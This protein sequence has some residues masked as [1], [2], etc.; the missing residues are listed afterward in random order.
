MTRLSSFVIPM[1]KKSQL[2]KFS[3]CVFALMLMMPLFMVSCADNDLEPVYADLAIS[4]KTLDLKSET[5]GTFSI[6][7]G[8]GEYAI[9]SN[10][11]SLATA[12]LQGNVVTVTAQKEEGEVTISVTDKKTSQR[13]KVTVKITVTIA[14]LEVENKITTLNVYEK[15][16]I[17][18][19]AGSGF[20]SVNT[21]KF[22]KGKI[23]KDVLTI[24]GLKA[25]RG[26][27]VITDLKTKQKQEFEVKVM[28]KLVVKNKIKEITAG[29]TFK[30][31]I[32]SGSGS[33]TI[34]T[35]EFLS[36]SEANGTIIVLAVKPGAGKITIT[37]NET[38]QVQE[39]NIN[40][41]VKIPDLTIED[42]EGILIK[43][44]ATETYKILSGSGEYEIESNE[45]VETTLGNDNVIT[46]KGVQEGLAVINIRDKKTDQFKQI[47]VSII[48]KVQ[49]AIVMITKKSKGDYISVKVDADAKYRNAIWID[50][51]DNQ[52]K[53]KGE[54]FAEYAKF[55]RFQV[56]AKK[57]SIYGKVEYLTVPYGNLTS[58]DISG[59]QTLSTFY[60]YGSGLNNLDVTKNPNLKVLG[61]MSN[62]LTAI[63]LSSNPNL[64]EVIVSGNKMTSLDLTNCPKLKKLTAS[65]NELASV[66]FANNKKVESILIGHNKLTSLDVSNLDYL[67]QINCA[68]NQL[69]SINVDGCISLLDLY[70]VDN[71]LTTLNITD[72][73]NLQELS[74]YQNQ[75]TA[76]DISKN[77]KLTYVAI[78]TNQIKEQAMGDIVNAL[79]KIKGVYAKFRVVHYKKSERTNVC[80]K[81]QVD[82]AAGKGWYVQDSYGKGYKGE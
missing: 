40:V 26:K 51:N 16:T 41:L 69:T 63:D 3:A 59:N 74:C 15:K 6:V 73:T 18:I 80:T 17:K 21:N 25:G 13:K 49:Q 54:G 9:K 19:T 72:N 23:E 61:C 4:T 5:T 32:T 76:L 65:N 50:L 53:D 57:I 27:F 67:K 33:Y 28:I 79:P 24:E 39:I 37:D 29:E 46:V 75:L 20:Y 38:Q 43:I 66:N 22:L 82:I 48:P 60:C 45:F 14:D 31:F 78:H 70:C 34:E 10:D 68:S 77:Q 36:A 44:D 52:K 42:R 47:Y 2:G 62:N 55:L 7:N 64:E 8:S 12:K 11:E 35:N 30:M 58:I 1:Q 56:D 71:K 81:A